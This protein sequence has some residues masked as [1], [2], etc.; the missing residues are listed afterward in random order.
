[1]GFGKSLTQQKFFEEQ[2]MVQQTRKKH[3][4]GQYPKT[5]IVETQLSLNG[6]QYSK[7]STFQNRTAS[8]GNSR[9]AKRGHSKPSIKGGKKSIPPNSLY[10]ISSISEAFFERKPFFGMKDRLI[11]LAK[12]AKEHGEVGL[13]QV[14][15]KDSPPCKRKRVLPEDNKNN[16]VVK[17]NKNFSQKFDKKRNVYN[18]SINCNSIKQINSKINKKHLYSRLMD[19]PMNTS[20]KMNAE[21]IL[22]AV[23][24]GK[25]NEEGLKLFKLAGINSRSIKAVHQLL[26]DYYNLDKKMIGGL[27][28]LESANTWAVFADQREVEH[29]LKLNENTFGVRIIGWTRQEV[30]GMQARLIIFANNVSKNKKESNK[31]K[32]AAKKL[33]ESLGNSGCGLEKVIALTENL[34]KANLKYLIFDTDIIKKEENN[35]VSE[36]ALVQEANIPPFKLKVNKKGNLIIPK[37]LWKE[38]DYSFSN[39]FKK[40]RRNDNSFESREKDQQNPPRRE[41]PGGEC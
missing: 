21:S 13:K 34:N 35:D 19:Q 6:S 23:T 8:A 30:I 36:K 37:R 38:A 33:I 4:R 14:R 27:A 29:V 12:Y 22:R 11:K 2:R 32:K 10:N 26:T 20:N 39:L 18:A 17:I 5:R 40:L 41:D 24:M 9:R 31:A 28:F 1:M 16:P 25:E 7:L 15:V 3:Q